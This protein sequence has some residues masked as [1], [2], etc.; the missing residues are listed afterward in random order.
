MYRQTHLHQVTIDSL[1]FTCS[2]LPAEKT[3]EPRGN[4]C[5]H[6][7]SSTQFHLPVFILNHFVKETYEQKLSINTILTFPSIH[8]SIFYLRPWWEYLMGPVCTCK[9]PD[10]YLDLRF[11]KVEDLL[12]IPTHNAVRDWIHFSVC[13]LWERNKVH[14]DHIA[15]LKLMVMGYDS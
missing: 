14:E 15:P 13:G 2:N 4:P 7:T 3:T 6:K 1:Q 8:I 5:T 9:L 10:K 11:S 12:G